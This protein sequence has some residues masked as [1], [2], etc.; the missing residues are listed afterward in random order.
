MIIERISEEIV[1][2]VGRLKSIGAMAHKGRSGKNYTEGDI[3]ETGDVINK[4][5]GGKSVDTFYVKSVKHTHRQ[6][7]KPANRY[8]RDGVKVQVLYVTTEEA[9]DR[10]DMLFGP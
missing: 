4:A 8:Y 10:D 2:S 5:D 9:D 1:D 6:L 3:V 7:E